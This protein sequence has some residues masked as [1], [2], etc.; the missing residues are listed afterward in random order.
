LIGAR[1]KEAREAMKM[2]QKGL[3]EKIGFNSAT[4]VSLI[5]SGDRKTPVEV[6]DKI[7]DI[8][9]RPV[10][11]FLGKEYEEPTL[12]MALRADKNLSKSD[13]DSII[14]FIDFIKSGEGGNRKPKT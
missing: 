10:N 14:K 13:Q 12:E 9:Q 1:I 6:L 11:Y 8:L 5:E 3:A 2:S 7:A 4:A